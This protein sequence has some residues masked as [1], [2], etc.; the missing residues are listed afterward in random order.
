MSIPLELKESGFRALEPSDGRR[1]RGFPTWERDGV[2]M[3]LSSGLLDVRK[4]AVCRC[5]STGTDMTLEGLIVEPAEQGK[6]KARAAVQLLLSIADRHKTTVFVEPYPFE[7][8]SNLDFM[9]LVRFYDGL[10]F[11]AVD[12]ECRVM[13]YV[14]GATVPT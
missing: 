1:F 3:A 7:S 13:K 11:V 4:G 10:G 6:G 12:P 8:R 9:R 14:P 2:L 5:Q